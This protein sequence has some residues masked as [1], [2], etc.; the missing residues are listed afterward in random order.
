M[1]VAQVNNEDLQSYFERSASTVIQLSD[2]A[3]SEY[4]RPGVNA[5]MRSFQKKP[6]HS[7]FLSTWGLLSLLPVIAFIGFSLF[8]LGSCLFFALAGA[9]IVSAVAIAAFGSVLTMTLV[10]LFFVSVF[11]TTTIIG[12]FLALHLISRIRDHGVRD[13]GVI[14]AREVKDRFFAISASI[15]D[16]SRQ[17][18]GAVVQG[19]YNPIEPT[20]SAGKMESDHQDEDERSSVADS[21]GSTV[22]VAF[23]AD[24]KQE[25]QDN[26]D[27]ISID[28]LRNPS[29][30]II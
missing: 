12:S 17:H 22:V 14:W 10:I 19:I 13:G 20:S 28:G 1:A 25:A 18:G 9:L 8:V 7:T 16:S 30:G 23:G 5:L 3:E 15:T 2:K 24:S 26:T 6:V 4:V 29:Y 11:L 21:V 27:E